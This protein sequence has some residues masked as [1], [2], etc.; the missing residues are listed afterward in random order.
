[1]DKM[2]RVIQGAN[3]VLTSGKKYSPN[4]TLDQSIRE[5]ERKGERKGKR[6]SKR[7]LSERSS[8]FSLVFPAI[9]P[10]DQ[11]EKCF[12]GPRVSSRDRKRRVSTNF[13]R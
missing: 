3:G 10:A 8:T 12:L 1:M 11:E 4:W 7:K 2:I 9:G 5:E 13:K 6:E